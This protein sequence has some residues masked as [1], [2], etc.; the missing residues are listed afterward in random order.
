VVEGTNDTAKMIKAFCKRKME[1]GVDDPDPIHHDSE[2]ESKM[3][4]TQHGK[5]HCDENRRTSVNSCTKSVLNALA[6]VIPI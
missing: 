5:R 6:L 1:T 4:D 3:P 2:E